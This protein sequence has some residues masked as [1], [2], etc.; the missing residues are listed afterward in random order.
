MS[1]QVLDEIRDWLKI[2]R[3]KTCPKCTPQFVRS[4]LV[5]GTYWC[6]NC[7]KYWMVQRSKVTGTAHWNYKEIVE[8]D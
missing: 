2:N 5:K 6:S 4:S 8:R 3:S 7:N 1:E